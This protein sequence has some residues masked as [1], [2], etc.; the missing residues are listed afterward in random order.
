MK[1]TV[2][3]SEKEMKEISRA[4]GIKKKGPAIRKIVMD[5]VM[6]R[7]RRDVVQKCV[8]GQWGMEFKDYEAG[9]KLERKATERMSS[10]WHE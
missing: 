3:F 5:E 6:V 10:L 7:R 9:R 2:E 8:S 1:I 4:T